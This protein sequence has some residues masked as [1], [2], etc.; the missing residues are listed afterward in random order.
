MKFF[1]KSSIVNIPALVQIMAWRPPGDK[2]LSEAMLVNL[3][4]HI[5]VARPQWVKGLGVVTQQH[6]LET[7]DH[8]H[9]VTK[10]SNV[11]RPFEYWRLIN[12]SRHSQHYSDVI[13]SAMVSQITGVS[14]VCSHGFKHLSPRHWPLWGESTG[15]QWILLTRAINAENVHRKDYVHVFCCV[16]LRFETFEF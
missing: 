7:M 2:P 16:L 15:D 8:I 11:W 1:P 5:C 4:A 10:C 9:W 6:N 3:M 12:R 13:M 14:L